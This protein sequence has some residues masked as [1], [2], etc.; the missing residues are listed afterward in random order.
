MTDRVAFVTG[1][2]GGIGRGIAIQLAES[3]AVAVNDISPEAAEKTAE[4]I[5]NDGGTANAVPG[6]VS[7]SGQ[8]ERIVAE[9]IDQ[10]GPIEVL[11]NN[12][13]VETVHPFTELPE[14]EWDR[15]LDVNLKG[16]FL[17]G[18]A[19]ANHMIEEGI[20][21]NI[22]NISSYHDTV[23]RTE[24]I[25]Y[26]SSK[27]GVHMLTKDMALEL[28]DH[29]IAVNCIAPGIFETPM[30]EEILSDP[31]RT[32]AMHERVPWGRMGVPEDIANVVE[33]LVS[34]KAEYLTGI[35]I[36]VDGGL[37]LDP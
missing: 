28:A 30:N 10:L 18:Q 26:D 16:Q 36:P 7:D 13:A 37:R 11:V 5:R 22:I 14:S 24:K 6:D 4:K 35:R 29:R 20:E 8:V 19:V 31:E 17:L 27:A 21:G 25:H 23:P 15:V 1:A 33:F 32:Q 2:G 34:D 12:A 3:Y 9:T